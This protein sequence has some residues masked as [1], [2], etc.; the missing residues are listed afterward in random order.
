[1][2]KK[3]TKIIRIFIVQWILKIIEKLSILLREIYMHFKIKQGV[4]FDLDGTLW[5][6]SE[7]VIPAWNTILTK[8]NQRNITAEEMASYMG[9]T[10]EM[11][12]ESVLP[13]LPHKQA[14]NIMCECCKEEQIYLSRHGGTLYPDVENVL[15][16]LKKHYQLFIVRKLQ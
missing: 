1:M 4:I 13:K 6:S 3:L 10:L 2:F 7:Q 9:K 14:M 15:C 5:D 11:I 12:A 8:H 16:E